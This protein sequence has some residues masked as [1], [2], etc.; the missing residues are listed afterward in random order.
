MDMMSPPRPAPSRT[1]KAVMS[2]DTHRRPQNALAPRSPCH[3]VAQRLVI[4]P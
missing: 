1:T 4:E 3:P 2:A